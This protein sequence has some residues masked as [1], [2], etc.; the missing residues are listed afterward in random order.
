MLA[1]LLPI[2]KWL[3][4]NVIKNDHTT[5]LTWV[6]SLLLQSWPFKLKDQVS[7]ATNKCH[8]LEGSMQRLHFRLQ[9]EQKK[10]QMLIEET[11][12]IEQLI[13]DKVLKSVLPILLY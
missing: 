6:Q 5:T 10:Q 7:N 11:V 9:E 1:I 3:S 12:S 2:I 13:T 4:V 8:E